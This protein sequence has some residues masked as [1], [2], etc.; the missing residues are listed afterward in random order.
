M[1]VNWTYL[2]THPWLTFSANWKDADA[3]LWINLGAAQSKFDHIAGVPLRPAVA[4]HLHQLY[5]AKG[6][7]GTVAI[8]GNTLTEQ[9]VMKHLHG[10]FK[11]PPSKEY[12]Q[13][14]IQN[15]IDACNL[16]GTDLL[17]DSP[18]DLT[19][20][21]VTQFNRMVL[22]KLTP[23]NGGIPGQIRTS[24]VRVGS[25]LAA[26]AGECEY[27]LKKLCTWLASSDFQ[28]EQAHAII[29]AILKAVIAHLYLVWIHPFGDGNGRT[30]RLMEFQI[31]LAAGVPYPAAHL[32]SNHYNQTRQ[33]Y[34]RQLQR[35][36]ESKGDVVPFIQYA[37]QGLIDGL[38]AQLDLIRSQQWDI[39][40][41]NY[42]HE[43]F[44][45]KEKLTPTE[46]RQHH[47]A[48]DL[49]INDEVIPLD[50]IGDVSPRLAAAYSKR[51][52]KTLRRDINKL[53]KMDLVEEEAGGIRAKYE[54][55]LAFLPLRAPTPKQKL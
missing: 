10:K 29:Y 14:E 33:E 45:N 50:K 9:E 22:N 30:A 38:V 37:L 36:S 5:L 44:G 54:T 13:Q 16:I 42:V 24:S 18:R 2:R 39:T 19:F 6:V 35:A 43:Q 25:Y 47:L 51:S 8:E 20:D 31:L 1:T 41:R 32:L 23:D 53:V 52:K 46:A 15:I 28:G 21:K 27:L 34:Y 11:A 26:P 55:I 7:S 3:S 12:Q 40:W 17:K 48:L 4:N 49:G